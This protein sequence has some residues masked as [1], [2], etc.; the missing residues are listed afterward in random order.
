M[1][2]RAESF[3]K[4]KHKGQFRKDGKTPDHSHLSQ[5]VTQLK[6]M[7]KLIPAK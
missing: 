4:N 6:K 5:V 1:L 2:Q 7:G 3:A